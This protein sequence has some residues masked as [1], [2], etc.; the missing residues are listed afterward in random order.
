MGLAIP[1]VITNRSGA[2]VIDGSLK[3]DETK[4]QHL[5]RTPGSD[6]NRKHLDYLVGLREQKILSTGIFYLLQDQ[7]R[8][9]DLMFHLQMQKTSICKYCKWISTRHYNNRLG[10]ERRWHRMV[11][12]SCRY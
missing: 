10:I 11:S 5:K 7:H 8:Q 6:G 4:K 12:F 9:I 2:Q 1:Q 3:F